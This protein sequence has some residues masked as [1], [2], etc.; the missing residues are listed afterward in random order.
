MEG[1]ADDIV[2]F[3][4]ILERRGL[5]AD[6][7]AVVVGEWAHA[8]LAPRPADPATQQAMMLNLFERMGFT[9]DDE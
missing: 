2:E 4:G 1:V 7:C 5:P 6:A 3:H 8:C 9:E